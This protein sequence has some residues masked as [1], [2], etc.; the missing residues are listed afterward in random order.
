MNEWMNESC[1]NLKCI[2]KRT[3]SRLSLHTMQTNPAAEQ[4]KTLNGLR[5]VESMHFHS[6]IHSLL[7][8]ASFLTRSVFHSELKTWLFGKVFLP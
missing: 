7:P 5:V 1:I 8:L 4:N 6:F 2:R 3:K